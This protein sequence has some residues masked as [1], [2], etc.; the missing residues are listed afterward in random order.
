MIFRI[1]ILTLLSAN[2]FASPMKLQ[3]LFTRSE[4]LPLS[5]I[6]YEIVY[7]SDQVKNLQAVGYSCKRVSNQYSCQKL[8]SITSLPAD[9]D[10]LILQK[11][12]PSLNLSPSLN[13]YSESFTSE[14]YTDWSIDQSSELGEL[15][16]SRMI[17][18]EVKESPAR[19]ILQNDRARLEFLFL[20]SNIG[21][22]QKV[23]Y[24]DP[25]S[26]KRTDYW[27]IVLLKP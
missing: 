22:M 7:T 21:S 20:D 14:S 17:W 15:R 2:A 18:R 10:V 9:V 24:I 16:F 11:A 6:S 4:I 8:E 19:I 13:D 23:S 26:R 3:G 27:G 25:K 5:K 1:F 12:P